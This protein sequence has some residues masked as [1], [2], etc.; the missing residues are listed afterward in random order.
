MVDMAEHLS[1]V[2]LDADMN[3]GNSVGVDM[4]RTDM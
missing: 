1:T 3:K 4:Q 2:L